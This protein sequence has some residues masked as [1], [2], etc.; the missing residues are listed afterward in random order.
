MK[1]SAV[2]SK[3]EIG[4]V[5]QN[6]SITKDWIVKLDKQGADFILFPELNLS[7]YTK[8]IEILDN[9]LAHKEVV[10]RELL[11]LAEQ[12][13]AA[14]AVGFPEK[15]ESRYYIS[16]FLFHKGKLIGIHRKTHLGATEKETFNEGDE[17][18][19]FEVG[20]LKIGLQLCF[21]THFPEISY[22]QVKQGA[23]VLAMAF[24]SPREE[25]VTKLERFKRFLPARAYDN[26]CFVVACNLDSETENLIKIPPV[27]LVLNAK[28]EVLK[29]TT[30]NSCISEIGL[31]QIE[32]IHQSRMG[33]FNKSKRA[34][35]FQKYYEENELNGGRKQ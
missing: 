25:A 4:N 17:I 32:K 34:S 13:N 35:L 26:A 10:F 31:E 21:E 23:N 9:V 33:N 1:L 29:E 3:S 18:N 27:A 8:N 20:E 30:Q 11:K 12:V 5:Q 15:V 7:G 16:H 24:A 2:S 6:L 14:F 22:A 28:G 19:I